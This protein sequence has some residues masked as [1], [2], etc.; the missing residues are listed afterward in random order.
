[1]ATKR[2][3]FGK[4]E[5]DRAKAAKGAA[6]RERRQARTVD[7]DALGG[8]PSQQPKSDLQTGER[9]SVHDQLEKIEAVH[10]RFEAGLISFEDFEAQKSELLSHLSV[11]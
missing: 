1:V 9:P 5:R 3:S 7:S 4:L 2:T 6:K 11:D 10:Q 8:E